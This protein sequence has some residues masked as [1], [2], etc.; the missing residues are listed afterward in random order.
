MGSLVREDCS[1]SGASVCRPK[2][3]GRVVLEETSFTL[4][5]LV[6]S[7]ASTCSNLAASSIG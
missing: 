5:S 6:D 4:V 2:V 3:D 1:V 7:S